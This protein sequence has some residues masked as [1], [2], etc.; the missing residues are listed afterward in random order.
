MS[1]DEIDMAMRLLLNQKQ[2]QYVKSQTYRGPSRVQMIRK[3][4]NM[5]I[6]A[7]NMG[8]KADKDDP[9][10]MT[11]LR[12]IAALGFLDGDRAMDIARAALEDNKYET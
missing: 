6:E 5:G 7:D 10:M 8:I 2:I 4:I 9:K 3:L 12:E 1:E 11:A